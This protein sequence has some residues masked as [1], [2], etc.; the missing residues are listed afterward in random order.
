ML[1]VIKYADFRDD[2]V[3]CREGGADCESHAGMHV[4]FEDGS[5]AYLCQK[6]F[7]GHLNRGDWSTDS[8]VRLA[9]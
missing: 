4:C 3:T 6:C 7:Q 2:G 5:G 8:A 9:L 1:K